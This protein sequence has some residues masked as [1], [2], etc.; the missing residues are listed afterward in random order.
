M[1]RRLRMIILVIGVLGV[2]GVLAA[3]VLGLPAFGG[4][5]HPY[6]DLAV[7]AGLHRATANV[8]SSVNFDQRAL[9]TFGEESILVASVAGVAAL[10]RPIGSER[11]RPVGAGPDVLDSTRLLTV[12]F[13]PITLL[14]GIDVVTHGAITPG[15]GFQ[16]G[17]VL[18][19]GIHLLYVGGRYRLLERMRPV[20]IFEITEG[21]GLVIFIAVGIAGLAAAGELFTNVIPYGQLADLVSSGTVV[22]LSC[23]VGMAVVSSIVVLLSGF[24]DQALTLVEVSD[25]DQPDEE[26]AR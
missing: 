7:G 26:A 11:K 3:G 10:L 2:T 25:A 17:V 9:D 12:I 1:S 14:V 13:F 24:L 20:P 8:V 19:T 21:A 15:G 23:A 22:V 16:G 6:R 4:Q 5:R 18:A